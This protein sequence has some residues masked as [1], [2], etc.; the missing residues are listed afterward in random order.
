MKDEREI[1]RDAGRGCSKDALLLDMYGVIVKES[2]GN[3]IPYT[4]AHF[5]AGMHERLLEQIKGERLFTK[6]QSGELSSAEFLAR[7]GYENPEWTMKDYLTNHLT[8]DEQFIPFAERAKQEYEMALLS[9]DVSEWSVFL[10]EHYGID[11]FFDQKFVS[12][13]LRMRKP[14]PEMFRHA[15]ERLGRRPDECI[16]VDNSVRNLESAR[17]LGMRAILFNRDGVPYG[18]ACVN[19]FRELGRMILRGN[20][21]RGNR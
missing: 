6:A 11:R 14:Q 4:L 15:C 8:L 20:E 2:K 9:N 3:F 17:E 12:G 21:R 10:T 1:S 19:D 5:D 18:G 16:F 7:L 13:A